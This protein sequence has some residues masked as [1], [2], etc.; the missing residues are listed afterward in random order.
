MSRRRLERLFQ[1]HLGMQPRIFYRQLR[2]ERA[3]ALFENSAIPVIDA[4]IASGFVSQSHFAKVHKAFTGCTPQ[5]TRAGRRQD[6][7][8]VGSWRERSIGM[9]A[10]A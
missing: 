9:S 1:Q 8:P 2:I 10:F 3:H 4:A 5:E 7:G 6:G